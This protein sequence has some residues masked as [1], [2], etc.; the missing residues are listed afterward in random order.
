[1]LR[2]AIEN[3]IGRLKDHEVPSKSLIASKMDDIETNMPRLEDLRDFSSI[4]N[5]EADLLQGSLDAS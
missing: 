2:E 3:Q 4:E 1:M 5:C